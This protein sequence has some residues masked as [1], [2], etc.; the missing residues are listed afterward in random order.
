MCLNDLTIEGKS[1]GGYL[2]CLDLQKL[3]A[4]IPKQRFAWRVWCDFPPVRIRNFAVQN[5]HLKIFDKKVH[6]FL[7]RKITERRLR[8]SEGTGDG[9]GLATV[10]LACRNANEIGSVWFSDD[11]CHF[12]FL[13]LMAHNF[14]LERQKAVHERKL[15]TCSL[16]HGSSVKSATYV[17]KYALT[18]V[19]EFG[20]EKY[21]KDPPRNSER[22]CFKNVSKHEKN[23][24]KQRKTE[25][26]RYPFFGADVHNQPKIYIENPAESSHI[27]SYICRFTSSLL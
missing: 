27:S 23:G 2:A 3:F 1:A 5:L 21:R 15:Q 6:F 12:V 11:V 13:L 22:I 14:D 4:K 25:I 18:G 16:Y 7:E 24:E 20:A 17:P 10:I 8:W 26:L 9:D 19:W